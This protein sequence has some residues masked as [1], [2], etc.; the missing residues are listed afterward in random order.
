MTSETGSFA[1]FTIRI[2]KPEILRNV[3]ND[4]EYPT[5]IVQ[6]LES[7]DQ[8][9]TSGPV[10]LLTE[11]APD[12]DY[13]NEVIQPYSGQPWT[14]IP[15]FMA[16][17]YFY[18]RVLEAVRYFQPGAWQGVDPYGKV[19]QQQTQSDLEKFAPIWE[20]VCEIAP[21]ERFDMLL[22]S[23]LWGNRADLSS[24]LNLKASAAGGLAV[25]AEQ[26]LILVDHTRAVR[27]LLQDGVERVDFINDNVG[28]DII[29]DMALADH[30]L[31]QG[32]VRKVVFHL[33]DKP[34]FVSDAMIKDAQR[35][36]AALRKADS[37]VLRELGERLSTALLEDRF[38]LLEDFFWTSD[39]M[40]TAI[41]EHLMVELQR[42]DLIL[43]KG[44]ANYRRVFEDRH[45]PI[46]TPAEDVPPSL[47]R[48]FVLL[49]ALK[50]EI[51]LGLQPGLDQTLDAEDD[52]W[53]V[54]G[55]RGLIH[56]VK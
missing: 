20:Q 42:S 24:N 18:R 29:F 15:W 48:P 37:R 32:W 21:E 46:H 6:A 2:R 47:P 27:Q 35:T 38:V 16:E 26:H 23:A 40:F 30:L 45:W 3:L 11:D 33:K 12:C 41:P 25:S 22:H 39:K 4:N 54:N 56:L 19:K 31:Q 7:F 43:V 53:M 14:D 1:E 5:E 34:M 17:A 55:R 51:V 49:R 50:S 10:Q 9:I 28:L 36:L 8:E 13:W 44:D 52:T